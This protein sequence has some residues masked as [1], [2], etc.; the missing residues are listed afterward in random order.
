[1]RICAK[2]RL[3]FLESD[4]SDLLIVGGSLLRILFGGLAARYFCTIQV[5]IVLRFCL[6]FSVVTVVGSVAMVCVYVLL[7]WNME[8]LIC[9]FD[10]CCCI[11]LCKGCEG[12]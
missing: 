12:F 7:A 8:F 10:F 4:S 3:A 5:W 1:M 6:M 11:R 9:L 2:V